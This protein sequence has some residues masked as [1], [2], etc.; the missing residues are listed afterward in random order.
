MAMSTKRNAGTRRALAWGLGLALSVAAAPALAQQ[1][2]GGGGGAVNGTDIGLAVGEQVSLP[3]GNIRSYSLGADGIVQVRVSPDGQR[4]L[5]VGQQQGT[6]TLLALRADGSQTTY[7]V[8]VF[9]M[10]VET[11]RSQVTQLLQGY[12][13]VSINQIG[14]RLFLEGGVSSEQ[15]VARVRQIAQ[16]YPGQVESLVAVDP[17]IV[18][19]RINVRVDL[20][21]VE[22]SRSAR[23]L[24]GL[25]LGGSYGG[26]S[27]VP[28]AELALSRNAMSG[29]FGVDTVSLSLQGQNISVPL[30]RLDLAAQVGW[31]R[32]HR[33][34]SLVTANGHE[35][36]YRNGGEFN[37]QV[38][39][40]LSNTVQRI[41]FG[42]NMT[43]TPRFD[44][45]TSRLDVQVSA[46]ISDLVDNGTPTP[47]RS[48]TQVRTLVNLLLGQSIMLSG[49]RG[50]SGTG[51]SNGLPGLSQIPVLGVLFGSQSR[52]DR[53]NEMVVFVVPSVIEGVSRQS[54][55]RVSAALRAFEDFG[56]GMQ[57][58]LVPR[59]VT[60]NAGASQPR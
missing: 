17:T 19:R 18:E 4:L 24:F 45:S 51:G 43:L 28:S 40:G 49:M 15:Q 10:P 32:I 31:A 58:R 2:R 35:A 13:G 36:T 14:G 38:T 22:L 47:G 54:E 34:A 42:T 1:P 25:Q 52:T 7:S 37:V 11:V 46:D 50:R 29:Q 8:S 41:E 48:I 3:A 12:N 23:Y 56:G 20:Y 6:T 59:P 39:G 55:D 5:L 33:V 16:I 60:G 53:E 44:P 30:P 27:I 9:R 21:F 26:G 57:D